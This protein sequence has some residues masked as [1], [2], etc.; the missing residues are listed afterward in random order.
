MRGERVIELREW[1]RTAVDTEALSEKNV[2]RLM[3]L[4]GGV[5]RV[6]RDPLDDRHWY[7]TPLSYVGSI[8]LD[9]DVLLTIHPKT[10]I[11]N[12]FRMIE[13]AYMLDY[14]LF[15]ALRGCTSLRDFFDSLAVGLARRILLRVRRGLHQ[16]Y[17]TEEESLKALRGRLNLPRFIRSDWKPEIPCRYSEQT[18]DNEENQI[19]RWTLYAILQSSCPSPRAL[20][21]IRRAYRTLAR[22]VSL[23]PWS[24]HSCVGRSYNRLNRDY[25]PMHALCRF[26]LD[27]VGPAQGDGERQ[28]P[29]FLINMAGLF[30]RF[31]AEWLR[32]SPEL[33]RRGIRVVYQDRA[34]ID[35]ASRTTFI[36]DILLRDAET[37]ATRFVLDTKY[38]VPEKPSNDDLYQVVSYAAQQHCDQS[39]LVYP[40][41]LRTPLN[42]QV[43]SVRV[44]SLAFRLDERE[45]TLE[46]AGDQLLRELFAGERRVR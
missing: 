24:S 32:S 7:L 38:K 33:A 9:R 17:C 15:D 40:E 23:V 37:G 5:V 42:A 46:E 41:E 10:E 28:M 6:E 2:R 39:V 34:V 45:L 11:G 43:G 36:F 22:H 18:T 19:L 8:P 26:F 27:N 29:A 4:Y 16:A 1:E 35:E 44:R 13:Y 25:E 14:R 20:P 21:E 31:V 12:V 3:D 30:E